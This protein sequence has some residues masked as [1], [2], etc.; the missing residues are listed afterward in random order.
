M[1]DLIINRSSISL[2]MHLQRS[3]KQQKKQNKG[4][5]FV[6]LSLLLAVEKENIWKTKHKGGETAM[7]QM[8]ISFVSSIVSVDL[9]IPLRIGCTRWTNSTDW[10]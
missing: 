5:N 7:G 8:S 9:E 4:V 10:Y 1:Y 3:N 2:D 6:F